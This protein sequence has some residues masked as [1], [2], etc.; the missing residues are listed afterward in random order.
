MKNKVLSTVAVLALGATMAFAAPHDGKGGWEGHHGK[1]GFGREFA[2]K[3]NL[4]DAQKTQ[5]RDL[6]KNFRETNKAFFQSARETH[7]AFKAAKE[8]NDTAKLEALRP[9]MDAQRA[10]MK[11][12]RDAQDASIRSI[13]TP[14]QQAQFDAMK[15]ARAARRAPHQPT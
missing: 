11:Q 10:Q 14:D 4:T 5:M 1:G 9:T 12:L 3:L 6:N 15:A 13:L 8:A 7:M 2:Q